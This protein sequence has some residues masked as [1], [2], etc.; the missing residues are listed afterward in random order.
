M[1][2][3]FT[4]VCMVLAGVS[5]LYLYQAK[6]R[7]QLL[8]R[9][10]TTPIHAT[11]TARQRIGVLRAEW[12]LQNDPERL[13]QLA[14]R[15]LTLKTVTPGQFTSISPVKIGGGLSISC[16]AVRK[17]MSYSVVKSLPY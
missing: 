17:S 5:G 10:I 14:D 4:C 12:T 3:P 8:D 7:V 6:H 13:A 1:I 11:E 16:C 15:F 2:R 9:D